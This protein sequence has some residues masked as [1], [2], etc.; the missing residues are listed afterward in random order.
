MVEDHDAIGQGQG[1]S[2]VM[3]DVDER[4]A[5]LAVQP[6][7]LRLHLEADLQVERRQRFV[8]Q[9]HLR[10]VHDRA[11]ERALH[12]PARELV[13]PPMLEPVQLHQRQRFAPTR[14]I[15]AFD[16]P[17]MRGPNATLA[18]TSRWGN[19]AGRWKT[20]LTGRRCGGIAVT[21]PEQHA[22]LRGPLEP[23]TMRSRVVLPHPDGPSRVTNSPSATSA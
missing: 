5:D 1:L 12:L 11:R 19:S 20:M 17:S 18:A 2:L 15:S 6:A 3:R 22:A 8:Q 14:S 21:S 10:A 13:A 16:N 7:E 23:A 9:Q 4:A